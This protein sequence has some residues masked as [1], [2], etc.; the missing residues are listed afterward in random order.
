[1]IEKKRC[2]RCAKEVNI[3]FESVEAI[4]FEQYLLREGVEV[5][6][7]D[8]LCDECAQNVVDS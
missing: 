2:I 5:D 6:E 4:D 7:D 1:M 3:R 8:V